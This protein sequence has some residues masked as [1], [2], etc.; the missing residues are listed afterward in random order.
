[1]EYQGSFHLI[2]S[3][4]DIGCHYGETRSYP[5]NDLYTRCLQEGEESAFSVRLFLITRTQNTSRHE[6]FSRFRL[7]VPPIDETS[8]ICQKYG[9]VSSR[10][11]CEQIYIFF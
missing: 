8:E 5:G 7:G 10:M 3:G 1:M 4:K 9:L 11:K 6:Q 2:G